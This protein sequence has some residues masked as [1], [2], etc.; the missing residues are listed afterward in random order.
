MKK[1][2]TRY[3]L[4]AV[5][6]SSV[7][8]QASVK[9]NSEVLERFESET[10]QAKPLMKKVLTPHTGDLDTMLEKKIIRVLVVNSKA[11][12]GIENGKKYGIYHDALMA[13][14]KQINARYPRESRH[15]KTKL[16]PI[17]VSRAALIGA[18]NAGYGDIALADNIITPRRM[19]QIAFSDPLAEGIDRVL[20]T[21]K[22]IGGIE[23]Y[24]DLA[25]R[26]VF[27]KPSSSSMDALLQ[28]SQTLVYKGLE[29]IIIRALPE[30]LEA[31]DILE[32]VNNGVV[33]I[34]VMDDYKVSLW[35]G[36]MKNIT[37]HEEMTF[38]EDRA[39]G[40]MFR[41]G[42]PKLEEELG[43]FVASYRA[44]GSFEKMLSDAKFV[45]AKY[46]RAKKSTVSNAQFKALKQKFEKYAAQYDIDPLVLMA[47]A[48]QESHFKAHAK[49][50]VGARGIMQLMPAT[51]RQLK[52]KNSYDA[53]ASIRAGAKY[54]KEIREYYF[55][56]ENLT[57]VNRTLFTFAGYNAGPNR[58]NRFR[59]IAKQRGLDPD[60]WF[61]NVELVA[62]EKI[63][64]ETVGYIE[65]IYNYYVAYTMMKIERQARLKAKIAVLGEGPLSQKRE[66]MVAALE[67]E[68][69]AL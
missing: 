56:D 44:K 55:G 58:I 53:E 34:T 68:L 11:L 12:Y 3:L 14:E 54:H 7:G 29:P 66:K 40:I 32:L 24:E 43:H 65:N 39:I 18:L 4:S 6:A 35:S 41:K 57:A 48:Y 64:R 33:G 63:G 25:G 23:A 50:R 46:K 67:K 17:P 26:E 22:S 20:V 36:V 15:V 52:V 1:R 10:I 38:G 62:A 19:E 8:L 59:K 16:V 13:L 31:E 9:E 42:S 51:A 47:Q 49:S 28:V 21:H 45:I 37:A 27:I 69:E 60:V 30:A 61:G 5:M 2:V